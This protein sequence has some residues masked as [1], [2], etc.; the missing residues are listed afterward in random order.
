MIEGH[1]DLHHIVPKNHL[2][3]NGYPKS[4]DYNQVANLALTETPINITIK[5]HPPREYMAWLKGQCRTGQLKLGEIRDPEDLRTNQV[6]NAIPEYI[7]EVTAANYKEFLS[8][9]RK[10]MAEMIRE[11]YR[12]L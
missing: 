10:L 3:N 8:E 11:H 2:I 12:R 5:D 4:G 6:E 1:G 9:R 7:A